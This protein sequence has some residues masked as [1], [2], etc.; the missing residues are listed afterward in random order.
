VPAGSM[1]SIVED[2]ASM[3]SALVA[4]VRSA[5]YNAF[6][7]AS[8]EEWLANSTI[9]NFACIITDIQ[10]PGMS[11]IELKHYL[12]ARHCPLPV[13]MITARHDAGL[14][15]RALASGATCFLQK[16]FEADDLIG[17][18]ERALGS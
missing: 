6:G 14:G 13:I 16:P 15:E 3:R 1:I 12:A 4:L 9:G 10:L 11:G 18:L 17:C 8:A 5:G 7:Y 2:D